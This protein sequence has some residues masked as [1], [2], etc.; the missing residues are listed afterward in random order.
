MESL[1]PVQQSL[2]ILSFSDS[3]QVWLTETAQ[4]IEVS[5]MAIHHAMREHK[6]DELFYW[7]NQLSAVFNC[8]MSHG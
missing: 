2:T 5:A 7:L 4:V 3:D 1:S 8:N 6:D